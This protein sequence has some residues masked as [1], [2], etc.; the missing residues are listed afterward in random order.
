MFEL[1]YKNNKKEGINRAFHRNGQ[2]QSEVNYK[3]GKILSAKYWDVDG[4]EIEN[5][6]NDPLSEISYKKNNYLQ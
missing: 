4:N 5:N 6:S 3:K 1:N 2:L